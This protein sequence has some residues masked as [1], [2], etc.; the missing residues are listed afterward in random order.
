M[1]A[2]EA[3]AALAPLQAAL[4]EQISRGVAEGVV[5]IAE[6][7]KLPGASPV[8]VSEA[9][10]M[11]VSVGELPGLVIGKPREGGI[12]LAA[13]GTS[14]V[15]DEQLQ[16]QAWGLPGSV[17]EQ[18]GPGR[19]GLLTEFDAPV[20]PAILRAARAY[21]SLGFGA[22]ARQFLNLLEDPTDPAAELL[23]AMSHIVDDETPPVNVF[24]GMQSCDGAAALWSMMAAVVAGPEAL[25]ALSDLDAEAVARTLSG[26]APHQRRLLGP[27][28]V[29]AF[30]D[31]GDSETARR[32]RDAIQR[33]PGDAGPAVALMEARYDLAT[34]D[35]PSA[36]QAADE[37]L[38][39]AGP[40]TAEAAI[41]LVDAALRGGSA[42]SADIAAGI[43]AGTGPVGRFRNGLR[44]SCCNS[45]D[46]GRAVVACRVGGRGRA[47]L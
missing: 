11:R 10:G 29:E 47:V 9:E 1:A 19:S 33:A 6:H 23:R 16:I 8:G 43:G 36:A 22:E 45:C 42:L 37:V 3:A 35:A 31:R 21:L 5:G 39:E 41:T 24:A 20:A 4:L 13:D 30:L 40:L 38:Q 14:C 32:L 44:R 46:C 18:L 15:P 34:G 25:A 28:L 12:G 7:P 17:A 2:M 26:L 27:P